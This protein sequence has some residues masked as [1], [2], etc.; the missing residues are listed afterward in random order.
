MLRRRGYAWRELDSVLQLEASGASKGQ[1]QLPRPMG[2]RWLSSVS[3]FDILEA[4]SMKEKER[5]RREAH[6]VR[7]DSGIVQ[8]GIADEELGRGKATLDHVDVH[9]LLS[10]LPLS[11]PQVSVFTPV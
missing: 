3:A 6:D 2:L 9:W 4:R 11:A 10:F 5:V 7:S 1:R 8:G